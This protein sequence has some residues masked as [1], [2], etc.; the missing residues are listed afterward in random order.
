MTEFSDPGRL[1]PR[2]VAL[3]GDWHGN[4]RWAVHVLD[5]AAR[6]GCDVVVHLGD[7]GLWPGRDGARYLADLDQH[8]Q[9]LGLALFWVDGNH[10]DHG[11]LAALPLTDRVHVVSSRIVHLPRGFRWA[12]HGRTW[13]AIGGAVSIDRNSRIPTRSWW[14]QEAVSDADVAACLA[15]GPADVIVAHDA[16]SGVPTVEALVGDPVWN[17]PP[18]IEADSAANRRRLREVV[19]AVRPQKLYHG[20]Y[21]V[22]YHEPLVLA[23]GH[24]VAVTGLDCDGTSL[25]GN[26]LVLP[27]EPSRGSR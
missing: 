6:R 23:D 12:W 10:D 3:A 27:A 1:V 21:H 18:D 19:D 22:A 14:S 15:G 7:F 25:D 11:A 17:L 2:R 8:L 16:P 4:T 13:L 24:D 5:E 26:L 9:R 20:H